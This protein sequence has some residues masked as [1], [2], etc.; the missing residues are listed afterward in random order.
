[1]QYDAVVLLTAQFGGRYTCMRWL[2]DCE[3]QG[4]R[5]EASEFRGFAPL[6]RQIRSPL[7][8]E[9]NECC[10]SMS[11]M[12]IYSLLGGRQQFAS[13]RRKCIGNLVQRHQHAGQLS[14]PSSSANS[15]KRGKETGR[16]DTSRDGTHGAQDRNKQV[17]HW[18]SSD[19]RDSGKSFLCLVN[20]SIQGT[21]TRE[22]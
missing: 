11:C 4:M 17:I 21:T 1:M 6:P 3:E 16:E 7:L 13:L 5:S 9:Q 19:M 12:A 22:R 10:A 18:F 8:R 2:D 14:K 20:P 15:H